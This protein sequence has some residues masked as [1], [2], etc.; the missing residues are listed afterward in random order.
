MSTREFPLLRT[1]VMWRHRLAAAAIFE[2]KNNGFGYDAILCV[3]V[4]GADGSVKQ[5][6]RRR[7]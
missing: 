2:S 4:V 5:T 6:D 7:S 3:F 1:G